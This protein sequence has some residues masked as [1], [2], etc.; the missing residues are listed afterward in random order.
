MKRTAEATHRTD[1]TRTA[2]QGGALGGLAGLGG[3]AWPA[4]GSRAPPGPAGDPPATIEYAYNSGTG[5][6]A[7]ARSELVDKF[8]GPVP[9]IK[10][11]QLPGQP[12][13]M[14]LEKFKAAAAAGTRRTSSRSTPTSPGTWW[15]AR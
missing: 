14:V 15:R 4:A 2:G 8:A 10:V 12:E 6:L 13:T 11:N 1:A 9:T 7:T 5:A 3:V